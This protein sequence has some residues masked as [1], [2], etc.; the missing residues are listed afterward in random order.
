MH[1]YLDG[2]PRKVTYL[3]FFVYT[4]GAM[5]LSQTKTF[6]K[7]ISSNL[8]IPTFNITTKFVYNDNLNGNDSLPQD[9]ADN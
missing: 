1:I 5:L 6:P 2:E 4:Y 3:S 8:L 7:Y 9:E